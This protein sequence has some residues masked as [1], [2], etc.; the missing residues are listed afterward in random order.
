MVDFAHL[1]RFDDDADRGAYPCFGENLVDGGDRQQR[2]DAV[3]AATGNPV[4]QD[5]DLRAALYRLQSVG[6]K[7][8]QRSLKVPLEEQG[9]GCRGEVGDVAHPFQL[10]VRQNGA[11]HFD[12][13]RMFRRFRED[14]PLISDIGHNR[15]DQ[16]LA[17]RVNRRVRHLCEEL[18]EVVEE[19]PRTFG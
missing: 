16:F 15:H 18:V 2:R 11:C 3:L 6:G 12:E 13:T 5:E 10:V 19:K 9:Q 4:R 8:I 17:D 14:V 7:F 1:A